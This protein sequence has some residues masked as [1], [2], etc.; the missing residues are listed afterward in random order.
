MSYIG[1]TCAAK[2]EPHL[3]IPPGRLKEFKGIVC[4]TV[5]IL[6]TWGVEC[7]LPYETLGILP[8]SG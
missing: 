1:N 2:D 3:K 6:Q 7:L 8:E 5:D 4:V